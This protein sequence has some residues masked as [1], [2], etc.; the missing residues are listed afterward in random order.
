MTKQIILCDKKKAN[1]IGRDIPLPFVSNNNQ[2]KITLRRRI[3]CQIV[4]ASCNFHSE[5]VPER[6]EKMGDGISEKEIESRCTKEIGME[7]ESKETSFANKLD[8]NLNRNISSKPRP[9]VS[10]PMHVK[11]DSALA[12]NPH[13]TLTTQLNLKSKIVEIKGYT[14][15]TLRRQS[16]RGNSGARHRVFNL[17]QS[18]AIFNLL[19]LGALW[20]TALTPRRQ[21]PSLTALISRRPTAAAEQLLRLGDPNKI[22]LSWLAR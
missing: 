1:G 11:A 6:E 2:M 4:H 15:S 7:R 22:R 8:Y 9:I 5:V 17:S 21:S 18:L 16:K 14:Y 20:I 3:F 13:S 10:R 12:N 19:R